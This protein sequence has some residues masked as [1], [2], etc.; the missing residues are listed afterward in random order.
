MQLIYLE[1]QKP[2]FKQNVK[3]GKHK[4]LYYFFII[5]K[6]L[7]S[8]SMENSKVRVKLTVISVSL[9]VHFLKSKVVLFYL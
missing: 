6:Y 3:Q 7:A 4:F 2:Y 8:S 9:I 5:L 1:T